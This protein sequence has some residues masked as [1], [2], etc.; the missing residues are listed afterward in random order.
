MAQAA[1]RQPLRQPSLPLNINAVIMIKTTVCALDSVEGQEH[2]E[3]GN[4]MREHGV[5][6][7]GEKRH[8][9]KTWRV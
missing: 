7:E 4:A 1:G 6:R 3:L 2:I 5:P 8:A 9:G